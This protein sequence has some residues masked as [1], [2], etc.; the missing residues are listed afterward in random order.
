MGAAKAFD[1]TCASV[2]DVKKAMPHRDHLILGCLRIPNFRQEPVEW[3]SGS[4]WMRTLTVRGRCK[5]GVVSVHG[6][7]PSDL[8]VRLNGLNGPR[9]VCVLELPSVGAVLFVRFFC[10]VRCQTLPL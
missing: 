1:L 2:A 6:E 8:R 3:L 10:K 9:A 5:G 4:V 7:Y